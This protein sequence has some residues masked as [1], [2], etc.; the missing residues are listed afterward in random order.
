MTATCGSGVT[1]CVLALALARFDTA[2]AVY[3]G[4][5]SDWGAD[6]NCPV[7]TGG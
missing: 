2:V 5:W 4:S 3:D 1:A 7:E 6:A